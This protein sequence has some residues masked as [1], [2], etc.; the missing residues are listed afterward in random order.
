MKIFLTGGT[1]NVGRLAAAEL[2]R[3]GHQATALVQPGTPPPAGCAAVTGH[4]G[5]AE[6][7]AGA[8]AAADGVLHL[9]SPRTNDRHAALHLDVAGCGKLLDAWTRGNFVFASS[10]TVYGVPRE[11]MKEGS[12]LKASGWYDLA[13][14]ANELQLEMTPL[15]G[16]RRAAVSVRMALLFDDGPRRRDRQILADIYDACR[17]NARFVFE[18]ESA[19]ETAGSAFIGGEDLGRAFAD[20][21][22]LRVS[23]PFNAAGG[24]CRWKDLI[25]LINRLTGARAGFVVRSGAR[26]GA[27]EFRLPQSVSRM[28][29]SAFAAAAGFTPRQTLEEM[30][31]RFVAAESGAAMAA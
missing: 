9:A 31:S 19:L 24:F 1:G 11:V 13:K 30:V 14:I 17:R 10:Q 8:V 29:A 25:E 15:D 21:L 22:E 3:R 5:I 20:A 4:L 2:V 12:P 26:P 23:G 7:L 18:S 6:Q 16:A 28:D 27:G